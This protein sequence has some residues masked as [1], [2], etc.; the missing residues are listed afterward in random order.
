MVSNGATVDSLKGCQDK[1]VR[2]AHVQTKRELATAKRSNTIRLERANTERP[3]R[4]N[5]I[6]PEK[7]RRWNISV[8]LLIIEHVLVSSPDQ[9][10]C[11]PRGTC[12]SV[13]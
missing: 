1:C 13:T 11:F 4:A 12:P 6:R 3:E 7:T 8:H 10:D 2:N 5:T 9:D